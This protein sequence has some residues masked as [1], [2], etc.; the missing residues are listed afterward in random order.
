MEKAHDIEEHTLLAHKPSGRGH[1]KK[2]RVAHSRPM[3]RKTSSET[4]VLGSVVLLPT[5]TGGSII[6][7]GSHGPVRHNPRILN[8]FSLHYTTA[9]TSSARSSVNQLLPCCVT[10]LCITMKL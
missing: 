1:K 3:S 5:D 9:I 8:H 10:S 7:A 4:V 6:N 2:K